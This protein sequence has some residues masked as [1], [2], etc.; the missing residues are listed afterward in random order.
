MNGYALLKVAGATLEI[1]Y[2]DKDKALV[3]EQWLANDGEIKGSVTQVDAALGNQGVKV[4]M[5][6]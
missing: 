3:T 1:E 6:W 4:G 5:Q 2:R